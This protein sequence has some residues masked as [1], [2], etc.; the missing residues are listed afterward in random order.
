[1]P[2]FAINT[3]EYPLQRPVDVQIIRLDHQRRAFSG[4]MRSSLHHDTK[5][6][7]RAWT[8]TIGFLT[9]SEADALMVVLVGSAALSIT[10]DLTGTVTCRPVQIVRVAGKHDEAWVV[11]T[12][13]QEV[14][15]T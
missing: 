2:L 10:G 7:V 13:L 4:K 14:G 1:M 11:K 15:P 5:H 12:I 3:V 9:A 8:V 6:E